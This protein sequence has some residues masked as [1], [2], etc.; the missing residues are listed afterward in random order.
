[1]REL[2]ARK[3]GADAKS[4]I[5]RLLHNLKS[6]SDQ[7]KV[8]R[9]MTRKTD[10]VAGGANRSSGNQCMTII[11]RYLTSSVCLVGN[12]VF[13]GYLSME[14]NGDVPHIV[15]LCIE[16]VEERGLASV[17]IYRLSGPASAIQ[18]YRTL[19]NQSKPKETTTAIDDT[20]VFVF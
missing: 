15:R 8:N 16:E 11:I 1:M 9:K 7:M 19:F 4:E 14:A 6:D 2:V 10:K 20:M 18:K 5:L 3:E 12:K 13:G 17:G